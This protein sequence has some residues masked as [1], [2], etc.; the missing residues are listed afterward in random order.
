MRDASF[1]VSGLLDLHK[2]A[3]A[4]NRRATWRQSMAALARAVGDDGPGPLDGLHPDALLLGVK[5][6]IESGLVDDL[7]WL[8]PAAA[9]SALYELASA[10]PLGAEQRELG[11]RVLARM[12]AANAEAFVAMATRMALGAAK[13]LS[14]P[15]ARARVALITELPLGLGIADGK[16]A[17]ALCSRRELAREWIVVPSTRSLPDRRLAARLLERAAREAARRASLGDHHALRVFRSDAVAVAFKRLLADRESLVWRHL[18]IARGL[19]A[20]WVPDLR[21]EIEASFGAEL[22]PTE[23]RRAATS[24][25]AQIA[26]S[27]DDAMRVAMA[28]IGRGLLKN[29]RGASG[30]FVWGVARAAEAEPDA[31]AELLD[32]VVAEAGADTA[33]SLLEARLEYGAAP[34]IDRAAARVLEAMAPGATASR[35]DDG[36]D[37]LLREIAR[38]LDS[39]PRE[40]F[41]IRAQLTRGLH[42]FA[43]EGA[44]AA[45]YVG[46]E[47]LEGAKSA[48]EALSAVSV[49]ED[50]VEGRGGSL[51]RRTSFGV[52]RDLDVSVLERSVLVDLLRLGGAGESARS[53]EDAID[54]IRGRLADWIM[55]REGTV[56]VPEE[57]DGKVGSSRPPPK[58]ISPSHP[59]LRLR[60][61]R[62]LL[63]LVDGDIGDGNDEGGRAAK[64]RMR[65]L[66]IS[67]SLLLRFEREPKSVLRRTILA[68]LARAL[69]ALVRVRACDVTDV[70]LVTARHVED[71]SEFETLAEASMDPDLV[72]GL[73]SVA[74]FLRACE[75]SPGIAKKLSALETL[76]QELSSEASGR[77][78]IVRTTLVRLH[79]A[80]VST[81]SATSLRALSSVGG[82]EADVLVS[83]ESSLGALSQLASGARSRLNP[84]RG[85]IAPPSSSMS[86]RALSVAVSRVLSGTQ[87]SL[88]DHVISASVDEVVNGVPKVVA[89]LAQE[90]IWALS[91]L[92]VDRPSMTMDST[93]LRVGEHLP[94]WLPARRTLG[95]FYVLRGLGAGAVGSVFVASRVEEKNE[96]DAERFALKVPDYSA[97]AARS[98]SES[99]FLQLFRSE[100]SALMVVPPH[101][102]LAR[103][104]T[105][106]VGAKPKPILVMELV[107][108]VTLEKMLESRSLDATRALRVLDE[109]LAGLEAM[110]A[111]GV[112]HLDLKP[113]NVVLRKGEEAVLVDFGLAGRHVRP[114]CATGPYGAPEVWGAAPDG[115][116]GTPMAADVYAFG[117]LAY[118]VLTGQ[119]LFSAP[120]EMAQIA[121]HVGHD[122]FPDPLRE[123]TKRPELAA[124]VEVLR[125]TLRQDFRNRPSVPDL[126]RALRGA[127][128]DV[129][130]LKWPFAA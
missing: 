106:D 112:G 23:R 88:N 84:D 78:E 37:A 17:L 30:A 98:L 105:F 68:A 2:M 39:A 50:S 64:L 113:S 42:A 22:S 1:Y 58:P 111:V 31:A 110:H 77:T 55:Q 56:L 61:L 43:N 15:A 86:S 79:T 54:Q 91:E 80:L 74:S 41:T 122:G 127:F 21:T 18:A 35:G 117:C 69:D 97:T 27:P 121:K 20:P 107:E 34:F 57:G 90:A 36:A 92:P 100:A 119:V 103:F 124:F 29:D 83:L 59:T 53:D 72:Q 130:Q 45:F 96:P 116:S 93:A 104:V 126:R 73:V 108:G 66:R 99:E 65:W 81:V 109:V 13:V 40:D 26:V 33:E 3:D 102:N 85:S 9:G 5:K 128:P 123:L 38:D 101:A 12:I 19:L 60:R 70:L 125:T 52:L 47:A 49:E 87:P 114:G 46:K 8:A 28:A 10:L 129:G 120:T 24:V 25:V 115:L 44:R 75:G 16:L 67:K 118:E 82:T 71:A 14:T 51:A 95:G 89:H 62:A 94:A 4:D 7:D 76:T 6:A 63:H 32:K 48:I 11:R